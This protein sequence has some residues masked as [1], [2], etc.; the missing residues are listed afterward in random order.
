M[1]VIPSMA[2]GLAQLQALANF[3]DT[4]SSNATFIFYDDTKPDNVAIAA[5][6]SAALVTITLPK[7]CFKEL[8]NSS[9]ELFPSDV[10][11]VTKTGT[12]VWAR[13]YNG[14]GDAVADFAVGTDITMTNSSLILGASLTM[15]S[16]I[17]SPS[18]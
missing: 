12:A 8:K 17:L 9:V 11:T 6:N 4:G 18:T 15:N 7:P 13:L 14:N 5:N 2:A 16:I 10:A 1:S 3:L